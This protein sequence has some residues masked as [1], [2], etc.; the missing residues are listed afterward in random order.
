MSGEHNQEGELMANNNWIMHA[1]RDLLVARHLGGPENDKIREK[2]A[3]AWRFV[4]SHDG[5]PSGNMFGMATMAGFELDLAANVDVDDYVSC[6]VRSSWYNHRCGLKNAQLTWSHAIAEVFPE[7]C[8]YL[9]GFTDAGV[10]IMRLANYVRLVDPFR[11]GRC[12]TTGMRTPPNCKSADFLDDLAK[13]VRGDKMKRTKEPSAQEAAWLI[14]TKAPELLEPNDHGLPPVMQSTTVRLYP[15][16]VV[17]ETPTMPQGRF[18]GPTMV[19]H[20]EEL[21]NGRSYAGKGKIDGSPIVQLGLVR[22]VVTLPQGV[23]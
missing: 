2:A 9:R 14:Q 18:G 8:A 6:N 22:E 3:K 5:A 15:G 17:V 20:T 4:E 21:R 19:W 16:A 12:F 23:A 1:S 10:N 7:I 11:L 13:M